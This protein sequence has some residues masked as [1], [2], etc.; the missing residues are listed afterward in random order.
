MSRF[1]ASYARYVA[2]FSFLW[3]SSFAGDVLGTEQHPETN[4]GIL[5]QLAAE[6][7]S[8]VAAASHFRASDSVGCHFFRGADPWIMETTLLVE[9]R[10]LGC[11]P[12]LADS[13]LDQGQP[14]RLEISYYSMLVRYEDSFREGIFGTKKTCRHLAV[15]V[16]YRSTNSR[17]GEMLASGYV[18]KEAKDTVAVD[19]LPSL[20]DPGVKSSH[21]EIPGDTFLDKV[22]EPFVILGAAGVVV[23]LFFHVR[24]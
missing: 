18:T 21:G 6:A 17:T 24:S 15:S 3:I 5:K 4:V 22:A 1:L 2:T 11:A 10:S 8:E 7:A 12:F 14:Y 9:L 19:E 16:A 20:E 13:L 23:Y